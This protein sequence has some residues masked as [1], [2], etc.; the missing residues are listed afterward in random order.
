MKN[1]FSYGIIPL[2]FKDGAW[3]VLLVQH[4]A[5]HWAF[6][7]GHAE[8]N[9]Q[10]KQTAERELFEETG[11]K[12][13]SYFNDHIFQETFFFRN[14]GILIKK[15]VEY[16]IAIVDGTIKIQ[17]EEIQAFQWADLKAALSILTFKKN[18]KI[19]ESV[20]KFTLCS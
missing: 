9:E 4:Q 15:Q 12:V 14:Q 8:P 20:I 11:L 7:K 3:Q 18:K 13:Q 10:P 16:F 17:T 2:S 6:P 19:I 1:E 5:G